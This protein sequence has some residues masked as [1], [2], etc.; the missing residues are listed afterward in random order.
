MILWDIASQERFL[1]AEI[2]VLKALQAKIFTYSKKLQYF[3]TPA[4]IKQEIDEKFSYI[5]RY[6]K[7]EEKIMWIKRKEKVN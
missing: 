5:F 7:V 1:S 2:K 6:K 4:K 3:E